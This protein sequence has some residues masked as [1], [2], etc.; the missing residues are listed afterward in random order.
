MAVFL[1]AAIGFQVL[2]GTVS[3]ISQARAWYA[4]QILAADLTVNIDKAPDYLIYSALCEDFCFSFIRQ[5]IHFIRA[6]HLSLFATSAVD[7]Y[8]RKG[9]LAIPVSALPLYTWVATPVNGARLRGFQWLVAT[10]AVDKYR[11]PRRVEGRLLCDRQNVTQSAGLPSDEYFIWV[12]RRLEYH[13]CFGWDLQNS[14]RCLHHCG[15]WHL[16]RP[17]SGFR[18]E[19]KRFDRELDLPWENG[20]EWL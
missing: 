11:R 8:T 2:L 18:S 5:D 15:P 6:H 12:A 17:Y 14:E 7:Q 3:G 20:P 16:E 9:W 4:S 10:S 19:L 13:H 1:T